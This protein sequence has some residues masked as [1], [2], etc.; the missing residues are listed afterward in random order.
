MT[1]LWVYQADWN[2]A[3]LAYLGYQHGVENFG[4]SCGRRFKCSRCIGEYK[5][6]IQK[7]RN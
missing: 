2:S 1:A 3:Y 6:L 7:M 4:H 5:N